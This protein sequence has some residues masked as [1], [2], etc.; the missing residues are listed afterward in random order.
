MK[1]VLFVMDTL[2]MGGAEKSLVSLL[3]SLDPQRVQADL[4]LFEGSGVLRSEVPD[5]VNVIEADPITRAMTL[6]IRNYLPDLLKSGRFR[7]AAGRIAM[8]LLAR[9]SHKKQVPHFSWETAAK[10]IPGMEEHYDAAIGYLEGFPDFY[11]VDKV[12]AD[13][14]IGWI[15]IDMTNR[16]LA[17][18]EVEV[19]SHLDAIATISDVCRD[20]FSVK[21]PEASKK[22]HVIENIVL[23]DEVL[24]KANQRAQDPWDD[25]KIHLVTVGRLDYQK[26]IDVGARAC[27]AL[28]DRGIGDFCWHVYG[29]GI[30]RDKI[31]QYI[32]DNGLQ[33]HYVLEGM[34]SNP[35]PY[36]KKA[37]LIVQ[38]SRWE[39]KS[40]VLDEA[41]ILGKAIVVTNYPSVGDQ[42][43]DRVTGLITGM[44][45][46]QIADGIELLL[47]DPELKA[48]LEQNAAA[49]QNSSLRA[50]EK[51][52]QLIEA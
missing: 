46:E 36:M 30:M 39:G 13:K 23:P 35:Y 17:S 37:E 3:K 50:L 32:E 5:W 12:D 52:Y 18:G 2:R 6:E 15:H 29:K 4:F 43:T 26:G 11:V 7:A 14:K 41:K 33:D 21:V 28:L 47:K 25:T 51:F 49:E 27:K 24:V 44:E 8:S 9:R 20:A 42:I 45:P 19:Y 34:H 48:R 10:H 40:I 31:S 22:I 16:T 38:P 1:R